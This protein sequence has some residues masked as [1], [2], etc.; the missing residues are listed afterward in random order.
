MLMCRQ[1]SCWAR[2]PLA[3]LNPV[4][5][6]A[7]RQKPYAKM[8][9]GDMRSAAQP[10]S[11][12]KESLT[13][14]RCRARQPSMDGL[15][16]LPRGPF[17]VFLNNGGQADAGNFPVPADGGEGARAPETQ[18]PCQRS[19]DPWTLARGA[20]PPLLD[21][22]FSFGKRPVLKYH[23]MLLLAS[24]LRRGRETGQEHFQSWNGRCH[25]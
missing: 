13:G 21:S 11:G 4:Q 19:T 15:T 8:R 18:D 16:V 23:H 14:D 10:R 6:F 25:G 5:A 12:K 9:R 7:H 24:G 2:E 22:Q 1:K 17:G 20:A 3:K